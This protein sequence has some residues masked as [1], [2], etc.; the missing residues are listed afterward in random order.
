MS[1]MAETYE[2]LELLC[3]ESCLVAAEHEQSLFRLQKFQRGKW[4]RT[5]KTNIAV[6]ALA[7][8]FV[9]TTQLLCIP[10]MAAGCLQS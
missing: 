8:A 4:A 3:S 6:L 7:L 2:P 9:H 5:N 10:R 1:P